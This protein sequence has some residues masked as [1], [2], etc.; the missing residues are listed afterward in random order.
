[1]AAPRTGAVTASV[2]AW[3]LRNPAAVELHA[4]NGQLN[5]AY[6][7]LDGFME[8]LVRQP[9]WQLIKGESPC[10]R[11]Y[12]ETPRPRVMRCAP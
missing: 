8:R 12:G 11:S 1:M 4:P 10:E 6:L 7:W 9:S 3:K 2:I 5:A